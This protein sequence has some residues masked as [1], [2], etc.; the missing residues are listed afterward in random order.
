MP[1]KKNVV[2]LIVH[3]SIL[4]CEPTKFSGRYYDFILNWSGDPGFWG[5]FKKVPESHF[6]K[7]IL[8][9]IRNGYDVDIKY[10][11]ASETVK[12]SP[13]SAKEEVK[14]KAHQPGRLARK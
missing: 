13:E 3:I 8:E 11:L 2:G 10:V 9:K 5:K 12:A 4:K 7:N 1:I 14:A 6:I